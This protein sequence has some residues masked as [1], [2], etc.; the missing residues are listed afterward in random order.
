MNDLPPSTGIREIPEA[1]RYV[2]AQI[3]QLPV[4]PVLAALLV[5]FVFGV[6]PMIL[7][8]LYS[9]VRAALYC[10][11]RTPRLRGG[12]SKSAAHVHQLIKHWEIS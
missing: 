9:L 10:Y 8:A 5:S 2:G 3:K 7:T 6:I 4:Q 1:L 11:R 12:E